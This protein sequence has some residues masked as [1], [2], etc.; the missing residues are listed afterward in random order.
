MINFFTEHFIYFLF[1]AFLFGLAIGSFLNVVIYR[2]PIMIL[3]SWRQE[4]CDFLQLE[5]KADKKINLLW[6][7]RSY[8]PQCQQ[9]L[10]S[11]HN[12]PI[13]SYLLLKGKCAYC[14]HPISYRYPLIELL[15]AL[16]TCVLAAHYG[17]SWQMLATLI[18]TWCLIAL[19]FIDFEHQLLPDIITLPLLWLGL[20]INCFNVFTDL[21]TAVIG[22]VAGY[23][24]LWLVAKAFELLTG[25]V[26]MGNGDFKLFALIGAWLGWQI[27]PLIIL[28]ASFVGAV[29][30]ISLM[31]FKKHGR[32]VPIP[33]GPYLAIAG[34]LGL[35]FNNYIST[36]YNWL[37]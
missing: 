22:A 5:Y 16:L 13:I 20:L 25:K 4:C 9:Q 2:L 32:N 36:L 29:V 18:F 30:G 37:L 35:V 14:K 31:L 12:I 24:S 8:C 1:I 11:W 28:L 26:G 6:P 17:I 34:W 10:R 33:F 15:T 7:S 21:Q 23:M 19:T 3:A 27:L